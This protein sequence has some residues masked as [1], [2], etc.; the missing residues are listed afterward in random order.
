MHYQPIDRATAGPASIAGHELSPLERQVVLLATRDD[1][2]SVCRGGRVRRLLDALLGL[3]RAN[4]L[5]DPRL[6]ALRR[7]CVGR[8]LRVTASERAEV[9]SECARHGLGED[10]LRAAAML[11]DFGFRDVR[12]DRS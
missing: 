7:F 6:E 2:A 8:R 11:S 5:A 1:R 12:G 3:R 9:L 4:A 10:A